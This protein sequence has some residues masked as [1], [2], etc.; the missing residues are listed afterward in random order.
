MLALSVS[1]EKLRPWEFAAMDSAE[2]YRI[3]ALQG[4]WQ[5]GREEARWHASKAAELQ[6][7]AMRGS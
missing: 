1:V 2:Y 5:E 4:A 7:Q 6:Q 3:T